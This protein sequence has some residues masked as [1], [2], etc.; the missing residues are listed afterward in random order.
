V[1]KTVGCGTS[2][3]YTNIHIYSIKYYK[4]FTKTILYIIFAHKKFI[5]RVKRIC[6]YFLKAALNCSLS[7]LR[8]V[9]LGGK[10]LKIFVPA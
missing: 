2:H 7:F 5:Y 10:L 9:T 3:K 1:S 6:L 8:I 4:Y